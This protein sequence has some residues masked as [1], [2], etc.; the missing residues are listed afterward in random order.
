MLNVSGD[1]ISTFSF[2]GVAGGKVTVNG[3]VENI[4]TSSPAK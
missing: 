3:K 4:A 2:K 1:P